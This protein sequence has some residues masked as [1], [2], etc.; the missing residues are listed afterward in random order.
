PQSFYYVHAAA[1][2]PEGSPPPVFAVPSGNFGNLTAGLLAARMG[3][4]TGP[5]IAATN[6]NDV[7]P[8][9]LASGLFEPR[10][11]LATMSN[12]MDVGNPSNFARISTLYGGDYRRILDDLRGFRFT[13]QETS[14]TLRR[15]YDETGYLLDPHTA[16]GWA[17]LETARR[18]EPALAA[19][20][21]IVL[22][23]AHPAKF[24]E[25]VEPLI[26]EKVDLPPSLAAC[27]DRPSRAQDL[28][29]KPE[30]LEAFLRGL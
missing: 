5:F 26:G 17:G 29:P 27:L 28:E 16:V 2:L 1:Q 19:M 25:A 12:A 18:R 6:V 3:L 24:R 23:T 15:V 7:V 8:Q 9:Y 20:P 4:P 13:D 30:A 22:A 11:S 10:P 14:E 21:G